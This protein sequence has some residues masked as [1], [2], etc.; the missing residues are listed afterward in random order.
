MVTKSTHAL[1]QVSGATVMG[2]EIGGGG[3]EEQRGLKPPPPSPHFTVR[4]PQRVLSEGQK[5]QIFL[6]EHAPQILLDG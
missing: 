2:R 3:G 4:M 6:G 1:N 5:F